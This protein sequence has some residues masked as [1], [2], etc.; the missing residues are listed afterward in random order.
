MNRIGGYGLQ[1][2]S[3]TNNIIVFLGFLCKAG[4]AHTIEN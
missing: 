4:K 1:V 2:H 3:N